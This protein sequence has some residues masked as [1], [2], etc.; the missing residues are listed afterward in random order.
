MGNHK[1]IVLMQQQQESSIGSG[2]VDL[3]K[4]INSWG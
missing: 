3:V 4:V 2:F 1:L